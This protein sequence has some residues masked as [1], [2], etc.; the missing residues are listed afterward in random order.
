MDKGLVFIVGGARSGKSAH[1]LGRAAICQGRK[2][3]IATAQ[4]LDS[5]MSARIDAHRAERGEGW[6]TVEEPLD[7]AA[8]IAGLGEGAGSAIVIDCLTL[9]LSNLLH[10][11]MDDEKI[12]EAVDALAAACIGS[13]SVVIAVSN[14]VGLGLVPENPLARRFRDLSGWMNQKMA[15]RSA[16]AWFVASGIPLKLK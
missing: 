2:V 12:K 5:E 15:L 10:S 8:V 14:E 4:A 7:V 6:E 3:Y 13:P 1:A 9:W 11:G 16:E